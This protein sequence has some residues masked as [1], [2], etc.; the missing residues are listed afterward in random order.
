MNLVHN[1]GAPSFYWPGHFTPRESQ[2][3][4]DFDSPSRVV[5]LWFGSD[6]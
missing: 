3:T 2:V 6:K 4:L 1:T 5:Q